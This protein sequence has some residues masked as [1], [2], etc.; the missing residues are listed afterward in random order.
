MNC[1]SKKEYF[2]EAWH[3]RKK[4]EEIHKYLDEQ[5]DL[6]DQN[7][8]AARKRLQKE[9]S[10]FCK[11]IVNYQKKYHKEVYENQLAKALEPLSNFLKSN[12]RLCL[13]EETYPTP[14][15][16]YKA[17]FKEQALEEAFCIDMQN[18][19]RILYEIEKEPDLKIIANPN[20]RKI[21][22]KLKY[23]DW[24]KNPIERFYL[25]PLKFYFIKMRTNLFKLHSYGIDFWRIPL[26]RNKVFLADV[27]KVI[28]AELISE[29]LLADY[30][31]KDQL[32]FVYQVIGIIIKSPGS[33]KVKKKDETMLGISIPELVVFKTLQEMRRILDKKI[34]DSRDIAAEDPNSYTA[35]IKNSSEP[36]DNSQLQQS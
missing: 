22:F 35:Y 15:E 2:D 32:N 33:E 19:L 3:I 36:L 1:G 4:L 18:C 24:D 7:Y 13:F 31:C 21:F 25:K 8:M 27:K 10:E 16:R 26:S 20:V 14:E 5:L 11:M 28:N 9:M 6:T 23:K 34:E 12:M 30:L 29:N 17:E